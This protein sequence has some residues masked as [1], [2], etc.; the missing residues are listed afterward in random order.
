MGRVGSDFGGRSGDYALAFSTAQSDTPPLP[1]SDIEPLFAAVQEV[2]EEA[3]LNSLFMAQTTKGF[4]GH[5][6]YAVPHERLLELL[7]SHHGRLQP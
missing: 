2:V 5:V 7:Q 1:E 4:Q 3:I 6:R